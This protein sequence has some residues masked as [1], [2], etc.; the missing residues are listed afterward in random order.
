MVFYIRYVEFVFQEARKYTWLT[1]T[2]GEEQ[3]MKYTWKALLVC[4]FAGVL[5]AG[6][7]T[8]GSKMSDEDMIKATVGKMKTA[9]EALDIDMLMETFSED[10]YHPEVGNKAEGRE[11]LQMGIDAGYAD[12]G[13][14]FIDDM[15]ITMNDDGTASVYPIDL[16]GPPGSIS[17]ELVLKKEADGWYIVTVNPDGM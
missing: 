8:S 4:L 7:A 3:V 1:L 16:S 9:L 11:M 2:Q 10:F 13:E 17:V 12:D 5:V 15:E 14:V 6:C